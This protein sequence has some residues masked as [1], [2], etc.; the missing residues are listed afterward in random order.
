VTANVNL[1]VVSFTV[2]MNQAK[3]N[4]LPDDVK[5]VFDAMRKEQA[6]W[7]GQYVDKHVNEA[8]KWSKETFKDFQIYS[9]SKDEL[10]KW[11]AL[12]KPMAD[13]YIKDYEAK[14]I[15]TKAILDDVTKLKEKYTKEYAK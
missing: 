1:F 9:L 6:I 5:K 14:G 11:Y 15:P 4:S 10:A 3:W 12:L 8:L 7:T 13:Q 2:V